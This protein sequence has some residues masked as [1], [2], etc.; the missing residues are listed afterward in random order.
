MKIG[1][2]FLYASNSKLPAYFLSNNGTPVTN[3]KSNVMIKGLIKPMKVIGN[4]PEIEM[5]PIPHQMVASPK[6]F[7]C[8]YKLQ[9]PL[10]KIL[11]LLFGFFLNFAS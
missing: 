3:L 9:T 2:V 5:I 7:G 1:V 10:F 4:K 6:E 11:P 8:L